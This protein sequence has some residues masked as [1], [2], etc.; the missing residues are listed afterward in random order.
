MR[1]S[2]VEAIANAVLYEGYML[3]PYRPSAVKNQQRF[4]FGVVSPEAKPQSAISSELSCL[5]TECLLQ[6]SEASQ[7]EVEVRFLQLV[8]RDV[9]IP[10]DCEGG[11][12]F[13]A[14]A[15][16]ELDGR[17]LSTWQE[18]VERRVVVGPLTISGLLGNPVHQVFSFAA[19]RETEPIYNH[20]GELAARFVRHRESLIGRVEFSAQ[21]VAP[22]LFKISASVVNNSLFPEAAARSHEQAMLSSFL[23]THKVLRCKRGQFISLTDP[24]DEL[25]DAAAACK[26]IGTW[27]VLASEQAEN[28]DVLLSSPIILY[29]YPAIAPESAG[30]LFDGT[31]IDEILAL[32]ILT[33]TD[34]E[35]REMRSVDDRTRAVL[36]RTELLGPEHFMKLHGVI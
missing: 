17:M 21:R 6:G 13:V 29:D 25:R 19:S 16:V 11:S 36:E 18:A 28:S 22:E 7:V 15:T 12:E 2:R 33:M 10:Q 23:S 8:Q 26:N 34:E 30:D 27:P 4:N 14:V 3:Y 31:E 32:R 35:K 20:D 5:W 24:P 1:L 9:E